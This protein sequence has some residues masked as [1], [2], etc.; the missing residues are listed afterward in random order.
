MIIIIINDKV[1]VILCSK[2][3]IFDIVVQ[4][5]KSKLSVSDKFMEINFSNN[6]FYAI[7]MSL[8]MLKVFV[9]KL[10]EW[11]QKNVTIS[12]LKFSVNFS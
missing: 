5:Q 12:S 6:I 10:V 3:F 2:S 11:I 8:P 1:Y 7:K 9:D 4:D